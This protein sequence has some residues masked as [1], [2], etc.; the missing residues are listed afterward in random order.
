MDRMKRLLL[1]KNPKVSVINPGMLT[2]S[3]LWEK[4]FKKKAESEK[5]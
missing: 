2:I 1:Q 5:L 3:I 4:E